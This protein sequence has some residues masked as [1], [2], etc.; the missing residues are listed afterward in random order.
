MPVSIAI[1]GACG[2]MG[3]RVIAA[4]ETEEDIHIAEALEYEG[5]PRIGE[6]AGTC[7]GAAALGVGVRSDLMGKADV[8]VDFSIPEAA[9]SRAREAAE[10]GMPVLIC[11]TGLTDEQ[12]SLLEQR[13]ASKVPLIIASN[14][15]LGINIL[16]RLA[17]QVAGM[18]G[19]GY[20]IEIIEAHHR[21]KKDAPS[22]TAGELAARICRARNLNP[23]QALRYGREGICGPR[24]KDEIGVLAIRGG[25][26]VGEHTVMF[27]SPGERLELTHK[28]GSRDV[29]AYGAFR[30]ARF[31]QAAEP[32]L[33]SMGDI[34]SA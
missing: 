8:L 18:L 1:N 28:A 27:A 12:Q 13:V 4:A 31:L 34:L 6:D 30:A 19:D 5:H 2:A 29:F 20:D 33:Y 21:R 22:G 25:D 9:V 10:M 11:T 3:R 32:G 23:D 16:F 14:T 17:E 24:Q 26:I 15:S 7:A